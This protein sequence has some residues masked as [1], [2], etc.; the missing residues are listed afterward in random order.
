MPEGENAGAR[1]HVRRAGADDAPVIAHLHVRGWQWA[2][3]GLLPDAYLDGLSDDLPRRVEWWRSMLRE[4]SK[5]TWIAEMDGD[6]AGFADTF[7]SWDN[8]ADA[9]TAML[10]A[11]YLEQSAARQG[12]GRALMT[13]AVCNLRERGFSTVTLW[14]LDTNTRARRFYEALGWHT[15]GTTKT[16]QRPGFVVHEVR[17]R[18]S[19]GTEASTRETG[20]P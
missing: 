9:A 3:R 6:S 7:R 19:L 16:E 17:Y 8:D 18:L 15:D 5:W 10:G 2:Y 13:H 20:G 11:I 4:E 12:V 14:V 1:V